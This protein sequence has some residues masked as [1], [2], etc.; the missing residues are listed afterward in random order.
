MFENPFSRLANIWTL[1][2]RK[3]VNENPMV[4]QKYPNRQIGIST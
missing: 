4:N 2:A 1:G 3:R